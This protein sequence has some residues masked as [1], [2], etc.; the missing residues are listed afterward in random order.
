MHKIK[1]DDNFVRTDL[2][3]EQDKGT[4]RNYHTKYSDIKLIKTHDKSSYYST[5]YFDDITDSESYNHLKE[6]FINELEKYINVTSKDIFLVIGLGNPKSTPDALGPMTIDNVLPT[7]YLF[8]LGD[9]EKGYSNVSVYKPD[10]FGNTG[11]ESISIIKSIIKDIKATK[12]IIIDSLKASNK[13]RLIKTIQIT[14]SGINPG[15][16]IYN[17]RGEISKKTVNTEVIA[18]GIP[19]VVDIKA[20]TKINESFIVTP[21]NIDFVIERLSSL[22]GSSIN[23]ILHKNFNRQINNRQ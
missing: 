23:N 17:N 19:T 16:G 21:T 15:S 9:V 8:S 10:V 18:I 6:I 12:V 14:N 1:I 3:L 13:D 20:L 22:L 4:S 2:I 11:I 5:I 7:R